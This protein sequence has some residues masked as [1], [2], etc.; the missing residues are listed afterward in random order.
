MTSSSS[1][2]TGVDIRHAV[3]PMLLVLAGCHQRSGA[4]ATTTA[5]TRPVA[6]ASAKLMQGSV[7]C[8]LEIANGN[9]IRQSRSL[10]AGSRATLVGWST[11]ADRN[12]PV[13]P[14]AYVVFRSTAPDG[15]ADVFWPA[16]RVAR[17]DL[18]Q[19]DPRRAQAGYAASGELPKGPGKYKVLLWVGDANVQRECDTAEVLDLH[20]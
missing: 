18:T 3:A 5:T 9:P 17:P 7:I 19:S 1:R 20:G 2:R 14:R 12:Q 4:A 6:I 15:S 8:P 13:P 16:T 11:V 10:A